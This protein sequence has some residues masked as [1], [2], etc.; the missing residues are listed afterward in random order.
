MTR[1]PARS[2]AAVAAEQ[3]AMVA[4]VR[5]T[6]MCVSLFRQMPE[7][8]PGRYG[9]WTV[10]I[11]YRFE[12]GHAQVPA[13]RKRFRAVHERVECGQQPV[14][15]IGNAIQR[16]LSVQKVQ[17]HHTPAQRFKGHVVHYRHVIHSLRRKPMAL[18]N[19]VYRES[20]FPRQAYRLAFDS[21]LKARSE[22]A[23]CRDTVA[24]LC[25]TREPACEASPEPSR[26]AYRTVPSRSSR[27]GGWLRPR[28]GRAAAAP[29]RVGLACRL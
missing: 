24:L 21:L 4:L 16:G 12:H 19:L 13:L 6:D 23:A 11:H 3:L 10:L 28:A 22:P 17:E 26:A 27:L 20:L 14:S 5:A 7:P 25:V 29:R 2:R 1:R 8:Q 15:G 9:N 18:R